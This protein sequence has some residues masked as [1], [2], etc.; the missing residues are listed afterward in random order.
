MLKPR[1]KNGKVLG[2]R[3]IVKEHK[4]TLHHQS[5]SKL[6]TKTTMAKI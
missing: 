6:T 3:N 2:L 5:I 4:T 1:G